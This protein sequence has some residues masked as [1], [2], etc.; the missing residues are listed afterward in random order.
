MADF[1]SSYTA[2]SPDAAGI[3][4]YSN[5]DHGVWRRLIK[6][7][8][9]RVQTYACAEYLQGLCHL[10]LPDDRIPQCQEVSAALQKNTGWSVRP[11][12]ALIPVEEFF[13][14]LAN[15]QFPAATFIRK[16][17]DLDYLQ[18]PDIF[19]EVFGHCPMLMQA[20]Y[21]EFM[22]HYGKLALQANQQQR[23][24]LGRLYWFTVEFGLIQTPQG[25]RCYGGGILSSYQE[26]RYAI[27]SRT[28]QRK[29]LADGL[30]ASRTPFHIDDLQPIYFII[31]DYAQLYKIISN[32][33]FSLI[34]KALDLGDF[35][36]AFSQ[37]S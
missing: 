7:Q 6:K 28:P 19:H 27:D 11:V 21:A 29:P 15:R 25:L 34:D 37:A 9:P 23:E 35:D 12:Q 2:L 5:K 1:K 22:Q 14:L 24:L 30:D 13:H 33:I 16:Q 18:E 32:D 4:H 20:D 36:P 8:R 31:D 17:C 26:T 10:N 3:V